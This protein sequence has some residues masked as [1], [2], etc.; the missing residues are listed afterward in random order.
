MAEL[1]WAMIFQAYAL[2]VPRETLQESTKSYVLYIDPKD[3]PRSRLKAEE[4]GQR[5]ALRSDTRLSARVF[6]CL[7]FP[8]LRGLNPNPK[9]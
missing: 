4:S 7:G 5:Q 8:G 9:P 2:L 6:R 3:L 1:F